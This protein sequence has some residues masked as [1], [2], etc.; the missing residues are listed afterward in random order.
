MKPTKQ[1]RTL[2][3][4]PDICAMP[5][6]YDALS[7]RIAEQAGH[8]AAFLGGFAA[9][10]ATLAEPDS[11]QLSLTE[12]ADHTARICDAV[13]I[14]ILA[15]ADTGF[16][17]VT[18]VRRTVKL[19]E[20]AGAGGIL[21][22]DQVFP[23]RCG[24]TPGKAIIPVEDMV[25]KVKA[26]VD[27]REDGDFIILARTDAIAVEGIEAAID[28]ANLFREAGADLLFIEAPRTL[29][30]MRRICGEVEGRHLANMVDFGMTP[31]LTTRELQDIGFSAA[32]W[33]VS[34]LLAVTR[35]LQDFMRALAAEGTSKSQQDRMVTFDA[36]TG[37]VGLPSLRTREQAD[38]DAAASLIGAH[39][40]H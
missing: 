14:P 35:T 38:L 3:D 9:T 25:A 30:Q 31:E 39:K 13:S 4:A 12:M 22:E 10:G 28:R 1:L 36:F 19:F 37:L 34:A 40:K 11:S 21:I 16:G 7:A 29:A 6:V 18:N 26:A 27:A 24:H 15:D 20:R 8:R 17:N 33:P 23:K 32:I 5:G 2:I